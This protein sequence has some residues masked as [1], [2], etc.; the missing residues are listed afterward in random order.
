MG[1]KNGDPRMVPHKKTTGQTLI[2]QAA[3]LEQLSFN[4][5]DFWKQ[6]INSLDPPE[7][8]SKNTTKRASRAHTRSGAKHIS[9]AQRAPRERSDHLTEGQKIK[10]HKRCE[11]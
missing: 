5:P 2:Q 9:E 10:A 6:E 8:K 1:K 11:A 3:P 7:K 4:H